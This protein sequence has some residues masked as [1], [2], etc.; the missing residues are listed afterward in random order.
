MELIEALQDYY[1]RKQRIEIR[2][3]LPQN[4]A[5][6]SCAILDGH[7]ND[8]TNDEGV[9]YSKANVLHFQKVGISGTCLLHVNFL[10]AHRQV[11]LKIVAFNSDG[12]SVDE[13]TH[14]FRVYSQKP[15]G[16]AQKGRE[17]EPRKRR[18]NSEGSPAALA[19]RVKRARTDDTAVPMSDVEWM[20]LCFGENAPAAN[21]LALV[22]HS[23]PQDQDAV[24]ARLA[25]GEMV[26]VPSLPVPMVP[27]VHK[28]VV[29][30]AIRKV[31]DMN[32]TTVGIVGMT[33][34]G[35]T[36]VLARLARD[37][38][39]RE[40]FCGGIFW[41]RAAFDTTDSYNRIV[42]LGQKMHLKLSNPSMCPRRAIER[43]LC[44]VG[45]KC[46]IVVDDVW[47]LGQIREICFE[48]QRT[49][50]KVVVGTTQHSILTE[51][52]GEDIL[53]KV[54]D[55]SESV[56]FVKEIVGFKKGA[57]EGNN[58]TTQAI[59]DDASIVELVSYLGCLPFAVDIAAR[60]KTSLLQFSD[61]LHL[62]HETKILFGAGARFETFS[63]GMENGIRMLNKDAKMAL[64]CLSVISSN[65]EEE[66]ESMAGG[67]T[68]ISNSFVSYR[69]NCFAISMANLPRLWNVGEPT[70]RIMFQTLI[71]AGFVG[72]DEITLYRGKTERFLLIHV[73]IA[74][75]LEEAAYTRN[76]SNTRNF[77]KLLTTSFNKIDLFDFYTQSTVED[78]EVVY[79]IIG[80]AFAQN[81]PVDFLY[82]QRSVFT[83]L[84][85]K[86][87][88]KSVQHKI[89]GLENSVK[90]VE[91]AIEREK[92]LLVKAGKQDEARKWEFDR[93][94]LKTMRKS[95][96]DF[97]V[98]FLNFCCDIDEML[99]PPEKRTYKA[100]SCIQAMRFFVDFGWHVAKFQVLDLHKCA[101]WD[102]KWGMVRGTG[103][104]EVPFWA[105]V[106]RDDVKERGIKCGPEDLDDDFI[107][108]V[109]ME[110]HNVLF[111]E[112]VQEKGVDFFVD[113]RSM[114]KLIVVTNASMSAKCSVMTDQA[115]SFACNRAKTWRIYAKGSRDA[116]YYD[117]MSVI[118]NCVFSGVN[119]EI[120]RSKSDWEKM[121]GSL[122]P[123]SYSE[124]LS[125]WSGNL[126]G[127]TEAEKGSEVAELKVSS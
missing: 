72:M 68:S 83:N 27:A 44:A 71:D 49:N 108:Y 78:L 35:K 95:T 100:D 103:Q 47:S 80:E 120:V 73:L 60:C 48:I 76:M 13:M 92:K 109:W 65:H 10:R 50:S 25:Y 82:R 41:I 84:S 87:M 24:G 79:K 12:D 29:G 106:Y 40:A 1:L 119:I 75:Y 59:L 127:E 91:G 9:L 22:P 116:I 88:K 6:V 37:Q 39:V 114:A 3:R 55:I 56:K 57:A 96:D 118:M 26:G 33:G 125:Y 63:K 54:P 98:A 34:I 62:F 51:M 115:F 69:N 74:K 117:S 11:S 14:S 8:I 77:T 52:G 90:Y 21:S 67:R 64:L 7:G 85:H 30:L 123:W 86:F 66:K 104:D 46:L 16:S 93:K 94:L 28:D 42:A 124:H 31:L 126:P 81:S 122:V 32:C 36:T 110:M 20:D 23:L 4:A 97:I 45:D 113:I 121:T 38:S 2:V 53:M 15:K 105:Y 102:A 18:K 89:V 112:N 70:T 61:V 58:S 17:P 107:G 99:L 19:S 101:A 111:Q 5:R 43:L